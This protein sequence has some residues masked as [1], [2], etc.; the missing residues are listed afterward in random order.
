MDNQKDYQK[1]KAE[2]IFGQKATAVRIFI[3]IYF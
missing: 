2:F 1:D 3:N